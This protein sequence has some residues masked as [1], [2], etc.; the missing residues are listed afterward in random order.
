MIKKFLQ[1]FFAR[2][3]IFFIGVALQ[4]ARLLKKKKPCM[5]TPLKSNMSSCIKMKFDKFENKSFLFSILSNKDHLPKENGYLLPRMIIQRIKGCF[6]NRPAGSMHA[7]IK[8]KAPTEIDPAG[9]FFIMG[10]FLGV[11]FLHYL[12]VVK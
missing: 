11:L 6:S 3:P 7:L 9:D 10:S 4:S 8:K 12:H 5:S 2:D 1:L